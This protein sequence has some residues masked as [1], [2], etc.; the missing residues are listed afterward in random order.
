[1]LLRARSVVSVIGAVAVCGLVL[2]AASIAGG[3]AAQAANGDPV[4]LGQG[5]FA[6][7]GTNIET[8]FGGFT[9]TNLDQIGAA[10]AGFGNQYGLLG[11][12]EAG[13]GV[14][15]T[16]FDSG[17]AG[18][19]VYGENTGETDSGGS[20]VV[21]IAP[22]NIGVSAISSN[23]TALAVSGVATFTRSGKIT[24]P[25]GSKKVVV[26]DVKLS[27][28]SMVLALAQQAGAPAVRAA[29]PD[30]ANK[31]FTIYLAKTALKNVV[32]AWFV[33]S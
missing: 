4:T 31:R 3:G 8:T 25:A 26:T 15:G 22:N 27:S 30:V 9:V 10:V 28:S 20:G 16:T 13:V 5:N 29:V 32:V 18:V 7:A 21:G 2:A 33:L 14:Y 6:S 11:S 19:G 1:M 23:G 17:H 24:V 12:T